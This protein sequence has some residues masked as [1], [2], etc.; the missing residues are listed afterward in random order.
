M[1]L[2]LYTRIAKE[3][4]DKSVRRGEL[5][6]YIR[7]NPGASFSSIRNDMMMGNG[8][9][10]EHLVKLESG[11]FI[12]S[13]K[14]GSRK[15]FYP[16]DFD[17][18]KVPPESGHPIQ[19]QIVDLLKDNPGLNQKELASVLGLPRKTV[20][21]HMNSLVLN[22]RVRIEKRGRERRHYLNENGK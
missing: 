11:L 5:I 3:D 8:Q 7:K 20:G 19:G 2:P 21:Y 14:I 6:G 9:L 18:S 13:R 15:C 17:L 10:T 12:K 1:F 4:L 22:R 16:R